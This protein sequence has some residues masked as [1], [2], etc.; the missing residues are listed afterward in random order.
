MLSTFRDAGRRVMPGV[1]QLRF[2]KMRILIL[3]LSLVVSLSGVSLAQR[4]SG[5]TSRNPRISKANPSVYITLER[6]G[7]IASVSTGEMQQT[8]WLRLRNNTRWP[9]VFDMRGV[10]SKEYGDASLFHD[11]LLEGKVIAEERCHTCSFN[12]V[13]PGRSLL[14]TVPGEDIGKGKSIRV[15]F[16]FGWEDENDVAGGREV[17]HFVYFHSSS[18]GGDSQ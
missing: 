14:F 18:L 6:E 7:V 5:V 17:E 2:T 8:V 16:S 11:V 4:R 9:I 15:Q 13:G 3:T 10:P 1:R 12:R